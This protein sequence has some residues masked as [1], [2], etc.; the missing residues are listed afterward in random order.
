MT[1]HSPTEDGASDDQHW[2]DL[3]AGRTA[4]GASA[5]THAEAGALRQA[6]QH[7]LAQAPEGSPAAADA[8]I[9]RLLA[10]A[11][12]DG[13]LPAALPPAAHPQPASDRFP[14]PARPGTAGRWRLPSLAWGG[15]LGAGV[16][17]GLVALAAALWLLPT[18]V[19]HPAPESVL[20][21]AALQQLPAADP[22]QRRQQLLVA[23]R[24]AGFEV[25]P[26][27]RLGRP[28]LDITLPV[29]LPADQARALTNLGLTPTTG[30]S[31]VIELVPAAAT[32]TAAT[33]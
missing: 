8:R 16:A 32:G 18:A 22:A 29:P 4:P 5:S 33:P 17:A 13:V 26:F 23:L 6:L 10:R 12:A 7:H 15:T 27:D 24:A 20:R 28:G 30:P 21:G 14:G 3:L 19:D 2:F 1:S 25:Q 31:L 11:R 9:T